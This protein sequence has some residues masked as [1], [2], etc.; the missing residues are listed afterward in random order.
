MRL[1]RLKITRSKEKLSNR[2]GLPLIEQIIEQLDLRGIIDKKFPKP[3]SNR[4]IKAS[5][6]ITTL[7]Y[8]FTDGA[9][10]LEDVNHLHNDETFQEML[11]GMKLPSSDAIGDWLRRVGSKQ[12][13][14]QLSEVRQRLLAV[15]EKPGFILDIDSTII[16][17]EKGDAK[18]T[19]K[20]NYGY[21]PLIGIISEN[22]MVVGSDFREGNTSPQSGLIELIEQCRRNYS[23][24]IKMVR[25][26]SAG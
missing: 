19:Y 7:V 13:E 9:I 26:D 5:D 3:G 23:Q 1:K 15:V 21:Q 2:I 10:H 25:I 16:E 8:M 14:K 12:T 20:G 11:K 6:Y 22:G 18:K 17:S 4:G 24:Q